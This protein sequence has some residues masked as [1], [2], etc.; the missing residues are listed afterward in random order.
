[1]SALHDTLRARLAT[2]QERI[3]RA[4]TRVSRTKDQVTLIAI[5]KTQPVEVLQALLDIGVT[6]LG[7]NRVIE[8]V[9][10][11]PHLRGAFTM[12]LVG[13]L[14]TN[15]VAK[16]LP[17]VNMVQSVDRIRL[18]DYLERYTPAGSV[19]PVLIEVNTSGETSKSGCTPSDV[20][21][22]IERIAACEKL[23]PAGYMT[24]GPL[25]GNEQTIRASFAQLS[26]IA[27]AHR[28]LI[29]TP[30][31]SMG[32]SGDFEWAILEGATMVRIGTL[33]TGGR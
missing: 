32:M 2:I 21:P 25:A 18:V 13:A 1:M 24:I 6:H 11:V 26:H 28:D 12:H 23:R 20:R 22:L 9:E 4:C 27:T 7:E 8:I 15:K 19:L 14:Q 29:A 30:H 3:E 17:L 33:L 5:T 31:L 10:K 16:V